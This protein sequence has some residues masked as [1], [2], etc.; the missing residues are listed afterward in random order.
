MGRKFPY[1]IDLSDAREI[2]AEY[3]C[4]ME[5]AKSLGV[6]ETAVYR[7]LREKDSKAKCKGHRL[8][9]EGEY[10]TEE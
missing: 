8:R 9:Y 5:C 2:V 3:P 4:A 7:C 6:I 10:V 1:P